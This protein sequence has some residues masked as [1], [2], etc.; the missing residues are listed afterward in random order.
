MPNKAI[1]RDYGEIEEQSPRKW[2]APPE[3]QRVVT[4]QE[5]G[6][7]AARPPKSPRRAR[8]QDLRETS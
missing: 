5:C 8:N 2:A 7:R 6:S 1:G 3:P 4:L